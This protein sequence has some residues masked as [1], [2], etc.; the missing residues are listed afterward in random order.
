MDDVKF[1]FLKSK[2]NDIS[3]IY[4][5]GKSDKIREAEDGEID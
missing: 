1:L 2:V 5:P 3:V 4:C